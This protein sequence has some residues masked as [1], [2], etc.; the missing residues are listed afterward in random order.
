MAN[1]WYGDEWGSSGWTAQKPSDV[2]GAA[3]PPAPTLPPEAKTVTVNI[4]FINDEGKPSAGRLVFDPTVDRLTD[5][6]SGLVIRLRER[7]V[8]LENGRASIAL[9]AT[10]NAALSP[11]G[12]TYEVRGVVDGQ[13]QK[14]YAI[15]LPS[16]TPTVNLASLVPVDA[17]TGT[18]FIPSVRSVNG[19]QG[20]NV[21]L[22]A[23]K[24][25]ADVSGAAA[26]AQNAAVA[27]AASKYTPLTDARLSNARTPTAHATTHA[28]GGSDPL[29]PAQIGALTQAIA[30]GRYPLKNLLHLN[31]KDAQFGAVG[32][33][34]TNDRPAI[35]SA[36]DTCSSFGGGTVLVPPGIYAIT[37][38]NGIGLKIPSNVN[39]IGAGRRAT[40]LRK[41]GVGILIDISGPGTD[42]GGSTHTRYSSLQ[43]MTLN[44][45][46]QAGNWLRCYYA[47]NLVFR[48]M[49]FTSNNDV[50]IDG[51]EF[52][53]TRFDDCVF[54]STFGA[55][56]SITPT[57]WLRNSSAASGFGFSGDNVN[58][59]FFRGCRWENFSNGALRIEQGTNN[60]NSPNGIYL[61]DN[62][63]ETSAMRGGPHLYVSAASR[64][65]Y[66]D[67]LYCFA[68]N[69][70]AGYSTP[71]N[72]IVWSTQAGAL[73]N[74]LIANGGVAT[75]NSALDLF[76]GAGSTT[77]LRNV[78]GQYQTSPTGV[79][80]FF[81][82]SS[83]A[84]WHVTNCYSNLGSIFGGTV[85]TKYAGASPLAQIA[86]PVSDA[87]FTRGQPI[88]TM[89][90][91]TTNLRLYVKTASGTWKSTA[92]T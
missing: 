14:P 29:T 86:G 75:I 65:V 31:V 85:P 28:S 2:A 64:H 10:D 67:H 83:T 27:D 80:M 1:D 39:V 77:V 88:G 70:F 81:E 23:A 26:A 72:I 18:V 40:Q 15:V 11:H 55:A 76:S 12:F 49:Y 5:P 59:I 54:E 90:L 19:D 46:N 8:K 62:K 58:Q 32:D 53:D 42:P 21:N 45:N 36:I 66:V 82:A 17:S 13:T 43:S 91:D 89:A 56:D 44:G 22:D 84:D 4:S 6:T 16:D 52:W 20:P 3:N 50:G 61:T 25:G 74:V 71:Q 24:V 35:Q 87:S 79:H 60:S 63:M 51:V 9:I 48:D 47:D 92:L 30:D 69:F 57:I 78:V 38:S 68:G 34:V 7:A 73:E 41:N 33:N 37:P